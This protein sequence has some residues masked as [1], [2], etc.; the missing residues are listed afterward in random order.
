[1]EPQL[2]TALRDASNAMQLSSKAM[3]VNERK[4]AWFL[5]FGGCRLIASS[6]AAN[7]RLWEAEIVHFIYTKVDTGAT[8]D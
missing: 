5:S 3:L 6:L 7:I 4:L 2:R 1:M 8:V